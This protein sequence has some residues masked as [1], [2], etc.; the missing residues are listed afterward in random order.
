MAIENLC[1]GSIISVP[2]VERE[3]NAGLSFCCEKI[4]FCYN[5]MYFLS[6]IPERSLTM[7]LLEKSKG[8][9]CVLPPYC[10]VNPPLSPT[11]VTPPSKSQL[12]D[13]VEEI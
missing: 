12:R 9:F 13:A 6:K 2:S 3:H 10:A 1:Q 8:N 5:C 7:H 4:Y 11:L